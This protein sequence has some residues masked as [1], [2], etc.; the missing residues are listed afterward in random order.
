MSSAA[1]QSLPLHASA[2]SPEPRVAGAG[3]RKRAAES[4]CAALARKAPRVAAIRSEPTR[5][6]LALPRLIAPSEQV[7][8]ASP[9]AFV[10]G[11]DV[12]VLCLLHPHP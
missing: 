9:S 1:A 2:V 12:D 8:P 4:R 3:A 6:G 7:C 11:W 10:R 5:A